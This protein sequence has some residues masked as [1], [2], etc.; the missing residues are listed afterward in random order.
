MLA[1]CPYAWQ[2]WA[3]I[4]HDHV[5]EFGHGYDAYDAQRPALHVSCLSALAFALSSIQFFLF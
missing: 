4:P 1:Q 2:L 3:A 5:V